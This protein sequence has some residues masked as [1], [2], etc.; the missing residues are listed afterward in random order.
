MDLSL[1]RFSAEAPKHHIIPLRHLSASF[2]E[3]IMKSIMLNTFVA[4]LLVCGGLLLI[5][6]PALADCA[7][8]HCWVNASGGGGC[9]NGHIVPCT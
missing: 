9:C 2:K 3:Q 5:P 4:A 7:V 6:A 8:T 1:R